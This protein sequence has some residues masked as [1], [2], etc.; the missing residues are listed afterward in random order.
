MTEPYRPGLRR[1]FAWGL[2]DQ[3]L[4][5]ATTFSLTLI[6]ARQ[7]GATGLGTLTL[8]F[9]AYLTILGAQRSLLIDPLITRLA[10]PERSARD[11]F[12]SALAM[13]FGGAAL[14]S[15]LGVAAG[16]ADGDSFARGVL[17]FAPWLPAA[18]GQALL[19]GWLYREGKG[20]VAALSMAS[21]FTTMLAAI[22]AGLDSSE[23]ELAAAWGLG[24]SAA[25]GVAAVHTSGI[26]LARPRAAITW[27]AHEALGIGIW[28]TASGILFNVAL[29]VRVALMSAILGPAAVGGYRA[30]ETAFAPTTLLGPAL[31][32]PG[33]PVLRRAVERRPADLWP[34]ALRLSATSTA[35]VLAYILPVAAG[36][37]L[38]LSVFGPQF[39]RYESLIL[40]VSVGAIVI[41]LGTGFSVLLL[42]SRRTSS[43]ALIMLVHAFL[44]VALTTPLA[45]AAGLDGAAWGI[46]IATVPPF[47]L[48]VVLARRVVRELTGAPA[49]SSADAAPVTVSG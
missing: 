32:N 42:A 18:L 25:F 44:T 5:S 13:T 4:S 46:A 27:F 6:A 24:A 43:T 19:S 11:A 30:I 37:D 22:A 3:A 21:W 7:V 48:V 20:R 28:R 9:T 33:I 1:F 41:G 38:V 29:Y 31:A 23:W 47:L 49:T 45:L 2:F 12:R 34:L 8:G 17:I 26:G 15:A 40:P 39:G 35:L 36:R 16:L 10:S 14:F